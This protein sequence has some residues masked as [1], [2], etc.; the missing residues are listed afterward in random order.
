MELI[1]L[2]WGG[3]VVCT[4]G[5]L[6]LELGDLDLDKSLFLRAI[7]N[8][9]HPPP[10]QPPIQIECAKQVEGD[11]WVLLKFGTSPAIRW[12][13]SVGVH[14]TRGSRTCAALFCNMSKWPVKLAGRIFILKPFQQAFHPRRAFPILREPKALL[15][16]QPPFSYD[17]MSG[18]SCL[19][20][21][22][23]GLQPLF[24]VQ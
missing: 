16:F 15:F 18:K 17:L 21:W 13:V 12:L 3:F 9:A 1:Q 24:L 6:V 2:C 22:I 5:W 20:A 19:V 4:G 7:E 10:S 14:P 11:M 8:P 23:L